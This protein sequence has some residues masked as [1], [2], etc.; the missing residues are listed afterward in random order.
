[1]QNLDAHDLAKVGYLL[2]YDGGQGQVQG[3]VVDQ[4]HPLWLTGVGVGGVLV[5]NY[6]N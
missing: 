5:L 4:H 3:D 6:K 1:M 2:V